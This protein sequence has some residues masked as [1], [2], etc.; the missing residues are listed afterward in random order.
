MLKDALAVSRKIW[1]RICRQ[2][3]REKRTLTLPVPACP[4]GQFSRAVPGTFAS[5][6]ELPV[7]IEDLI[8]QVLE[9][10]WFSFEA[11][12]LAAGVIARLRELVGDIPASADHHHSE[13]YGLMRHS[14]EVAVKMLNEFEK[15]KTSDDSAQWQYLAFLAGL[16]HDLGKLFDMELEA[17]D[18][19]WSPLHETHAEFLQDL[20]V[21]PVLSWDEGRVRGGHAQLAPWLMHH[22]LTPA[23]IQFIGVE[24]LPQLASAL[25]GTHVSERSAP[26][27]RLVTKLDQESVEEA[28]P[29]WMTKLPDSK[30]NQ[31]IRALRDLISDGGLSVNTPGAPI[32]VMG[33]RA[34]VV[35]PLSVCVARDYLKRHEN[36]KLPCNHRLYDLLAQAEI[37]E[38]DE[39]RQ[40]VKRIK[41]RGKHGL[42]ELSAVIFN[43]QTIIPHQILTTLPKVKFEIVPEELEPAVVVANSDARK[44]A[45]LCKPLG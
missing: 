42:V 14:L 41:V 27:V 4:Q 30:V 16:C 9:R 21:E 18:R 22:L 35:V 15:I 37:V 10:I 39:S 26:L 23:D 43:Q 2:I 11:R 32:Y 8:D 12:N 40:C 36:I 7:A 20:K 38:A 33:D 3:F 28:A 44:P 5:P 6:P 45:P 25:T 13:S 34:A 17:E 1:R 19:R 31:F 29:E 24:R